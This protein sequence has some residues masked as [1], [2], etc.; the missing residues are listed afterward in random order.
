MGR[1]VTPMLNSALLAVLFTVL[2]PTL[3]F[4][5]ETTETESQSTCGQEEKDIDQE[6][7]GS[8][9][10]TSPRKWNRF[11]GDSSPSNLVRAPSAGSI[12]VSSGRPDSLVETESIQGFR[13]GPALAQSM[14]FL[15]IQHGLRLTGDAGPVFTIGANRTRRELKG[16]F[17]QDWFDSLKTLKGWD[18]G[19][20]FRTNYI[21]HP[22][23]GAASGRIQIH[24]DPSGNLLEFENTSA[25]W[26]SRLKAMGWATLYSTQFELGPLSEASLGNVGTAPGH[27]SLSYVDL[28]ITPTLGTG[29]LIGEDLLDLYVIKPYEKKSTSPGWVGLV[30][31][32]LNPMRGFA[33]LL[34]FKKPWH[35]D[36]R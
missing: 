1:F 4:G 26:K 31:L 25:Y 6:Q 24:N 22:M 9:A 27:R 17:F 5:Q 19:S 2:L 20:H 12:R 7:S 34:R 18:D 36:T 3:C 28:V 16:P 33:N 11:E 30:R 21:F 15:G 14:L 13:W 35:R 32:L 29:F 8:Q 10:A 23:Q